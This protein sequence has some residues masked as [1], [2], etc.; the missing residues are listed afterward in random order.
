M[1]ITAQ[2]SI[3]AV[4]FSSTIL[5]VLMLLSGS[6]SIAQTTKPKPVTASDS[7]TRAVSDSFAKSPAYEDLLKKIDNLIN[8]QKYQAA[9]DLANSESAKI[10]EPLDQAR[11]MTKIIQL[12]TGL[13]DYET[14]VNHFREKKWP[15]DVRSQTLLNIFYAHSLQQYARSYSWE[16]RQRTKVAS[17]AQKDLKT[18]TVEE[19]YADAILSLA[20]VWPSREALGN[21]PKTALSD[22][23][24]PNTYPA[25]VRDSLR[26]SYTMLFAR[27]LNDSSGWTPEQSNELFRLNLSTLMSGQNSQGVDLKSVKPHPL[28]KIS[29]L[30]FDLKIWHE[31]NGR[32][33]AATDAQ[34]ELL[35][36]LHQRFT[37]DKDRDKIRDRLTDLLKAS[38][39]TPWSTMVAGS[40]AS[41]WMQ[42][43]APDALNT[44]RK[45]A[46]QA[47]DAFPDSLGAK[48]CR[49]LIRQIDS[50]A[51]QLQ[52]M[53]VD[54]ES[55]RSL[56]LQYKNLTKVHFLA[57]KYDFKKFIED[58]QDYNHYPSYRELEAFTKMKPTLTWS[59]EL[60]ATTDYRSHKAFITP[61]KMEPGFYVIAA[62]MEP[63]LKPDMNI[64]SGTMM[65]FSDMVISYRPENGSTVFT[66]RNGETGKLEKDAKLL[67][68][69][70]E[71]NKRNSLEA[72]LK[73]DANGQATFKLP[74]S[75]GR[76]GNFGVF[77][78]KNKGYSFA[79]FNAWSDSGQ[80]SHNAMA[81]MYSD[82]A[83]YRPEQKLYW[84]SIYYQTTDTVGK[85]KLLTNS[86]QTVSLVDINGQVVAKKEVTTDSFGAAWGEFNIPS[87]RALGQWSLQT[88]GGSQPVR[89]EE[90]KRPTFELSWKEQK[91]PLRL[92]QKAEVVGEAKY[93]FGSPL[94]SGR[95]RYTVQRQLILPWWCFWGSYSWSGLQRPQVIA[96]NETKIENDGTFKIQFL[97]EADTRL[98]KGADDLR[99]NYT[100]DTEVLDDGGETRTSEKVVSIGTKSVEATVSVSGGWQLE[101]KAL[102][103]SLRR[104]LLMGDPAPG[105][106]TWKLMKLNEPAAVTMPADLKAPSYLRAVLPT[107]LQFS[108]DLLQP[109]WAT[110]YNWSAV[111][112]DWTAG[113][114]ISKGSVEAD[115]KGAGEIKLPGLKAGAYRLIYETKDSYG[116]KVESQTE[117][118]IANETYRPK[119]PAL[120]L[121]SQTSAKVGE[122][123]LFWIPSGLKDQTLIFEHFQDGKWLKHQIL[124]SSKD[125]AL[126]RWPV[127]ESMRGGMGFTL[128]L[129][130]DYQ[131]VEL[132]QSLFVPWDNKEISVEFA[133]FRDKLRPGQEETWTVRLKGPEK[134]KVEQGSVQLLAY[135]Y[136]RSLDQL[137]PHSSASLLSIYPGRSGYSFA[138]TDLGVGINAYF[139]YSL[140]YPTEFYPPTEDSPIYFSNYGIGGPGR[141]GHMNYL[142]KSAPMPMSAPPEEAMASSVMEDAAPAPARE[143]KAKAE[144]EGDVAG[145]AQRKDSD[146]AKKEFRAESGAAA[147]PKTPEALRSNFS[148]TAFFFPNLKSGKNGEVEI[149]FKVPDSVT[150]WNLFLQGLTQDLKSVTA[151]KQ[152]ETVKELMIRPYLPRFLREG[153]KAQIRFVLNNTSS[154]PLSGQIQI[155][156]LDADGKTDVSQKFKVAAAK[157]KNVP[158]QMAAMKNFTHEID[159]VVPAGLGSLMVKAVAKSGPV[160]DGELRNLPILP[161]RFHLAQSKFVTLK[162]K[163][164]KTLE[165]A[166]LKSNSDPSLINEKMVIQIDAQLF[167]SVLSALPYLVNYPYECTEQT[168]NRFL[169]TGIMTS[170]FKQFPSIEKMAKDFSARKSQFEKFDEADPNRRMALEETPWLNEAK[171]GAE[172]GENLINVL[173]SKIANET[174]TSA[175]RK[176]EK[177]QTSLGGFPWFEGGPPSPYITLYIVYG[178]SKALEFGV[179]VPKGMVRQAWGYLHRH[180]IDEIVRTCM[181]LDSCWETITFLNYVISNYPSAGWGQE[182]FTDAERKAMLDFSF[183]HWKEHSP[184]LKGYLSLTLSRAKRPQDAK[185]VWDSVM[186][187]AK[188]NPEEGT[189]WAREDRSWLWYNDTIETHAFALRTLME[190]GSDNVKRDGLVQWLFLNKKLNHW[191]ST[192]ATSEVIYS[193]AHYLKNTNQLGVREA[194]N[195]KIG[196]EKPIEMEFLPEKYTGKKNQIVY[197]GEKISSALMPVVVQKSTPGFMFASANWQFSTEKLPPAAVGDFLSVDRKFFLRD[198]SGKEFMLRPLAEGQKIRVGDE[199]EVHLGLRSKHPVGY[200]HL[201]DP[202]GAGFEPVDGNSK[203]KWDLGIYWYEEIRDS[204]TNFFFESL[205][206]GEYTFKYRLRATTAGEYKVSPATVQPMYAPEFAAYSSGLK[207]QIASDKNQ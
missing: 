165:F 179:E 113:E 143:A 51:L 131:K 47:A 193:L 45:I 30:L 61:P 16:I 38:E 62:A 127:K 42:N 144:A 36:T 178:F 100:I 167:Y 49:D 111:V 188:S 54:G 205:P 139:N 7:A 34:L 206:Q 96:T 39:K 102:S 128:R 73:T 23:I 140:P 81:I 166:D 125:S 99:Y 24:S 150:S 122:E 76:Y 43:E 104:S 192:R 175:L 56:E 87:G 75:N 25:G 12:E 133:S 70:F 32:K 14:A 93:Y 152:S 195:I 200:V 59:T 9:L 202:R 196:N 48:R 141:R 18:W 136:D 53:K 55:K 201:R 8:E 52:T 116:V 159:L 158:F 94:T 191:K 27:L 187:S 184:Y 15:A 199:V 198:K 74:L 58:S 78:E 46:S 119:L 80:R 151:T 92:N 101:D 33:D 26:E 89:V 171:G 13:H 88:N 132:G 148:E 63:T 82:R 168:L 83:I 69:K 10:K 60:K 160:S 110:N 174:R 112:R 22:F 137:A 126:I 105:A 176:L 31:K 147:T 207:I 123:V 90:Y 185:L 57:F 186:D 124:N 130:N 37:N 121:A 154:K 72:T 98:A 103:V 109:R 67:I 153:D 85:Y 1:K 2:K 71:Y 204:G 190:L 64:I 163:D 134:S 156:L 44:A 28:E 189:H 117:F 19:I 114:Q 145:F 138:A 115:A 77:A 161:G 149:K 29:N 95:V 162:D 66:I 97:P 170:L 155:E 164:K 79:E 197:E 194:V 5:S 129:L 107:G 180:Y 6:G 11:L 91:A 169:S 21:Y 181:A 35:E 203:H 20:S 142:S 182:V 40:L 65:F 4:A 41:I 172:P 135:M 173:D 183:R 86:Q 157:L 108:D 84:K 50:P 17:T 120:F 146:K 177:S 3:F 106:G 118:F 68:Y